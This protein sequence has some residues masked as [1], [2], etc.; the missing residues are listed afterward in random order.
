VE[1]FGYLEMAQHRSHIVVGV[2]VGG[3]EKNIAVAGRINFGIISQQRYTN[4]LVYQ[5]S[6]EINLYL[7]CMSRIR[8]RS[9]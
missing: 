6:R 4:L 7:Y 9:R 5:I 1:Y 2:C 3:K 8:L